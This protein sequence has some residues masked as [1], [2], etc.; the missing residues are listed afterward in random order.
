M[1]QRQT[2]DLWLA[3][4][5][6]LITAGWTLFLASWLVPIFIVLAIALKVDMIG[7]GHSK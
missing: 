2:D 1:K 4:R 3:V 6:V 7:I 5:N